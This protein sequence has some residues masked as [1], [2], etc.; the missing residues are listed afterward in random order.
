MCVHVS[1]SDLWAWSYR[2]VWMGESMVSL[3]SNTA[4]HANGKSRLLRGTWSVVSSAVCWR[5]LTATLHW[6]RE[7]RLSSNATKTEGI[8]ITP[9]HFTEADFIPWSSYII[10]VR[11]FLLPYSGKFLGVQIFSVFTINQLSAKLKMLL[12]TTGMLI[13]IWK[14]WACEMLQNTRMKIEPREIFPLYGLLV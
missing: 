4:K 9:M 5:P 13:C 14:N 1:S 6:E 11:R 10:K 12:R 7:D 2:L 8:R 3:V